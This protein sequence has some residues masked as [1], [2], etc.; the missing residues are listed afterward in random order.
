MDLEQTKVAIK[1]LYNHRYHSLNKRVSYALKQAKEDLDIDFGLLSLHEMKTVSNTIVDLECEKTHDELEDLL[2]QKEAIESKLQH[3]KQEL[4]NIKY[5]IFNTLEEQLNEDDT[6]SVSKLHQIK[7]QSIDIY[8]I[9]SETVESAII[10]AQE[11]STDIQKNDNIQVIITEITYQ[12]IKEGSLN[13]IRTRKILSTILHSVITVA[14]ADPNNGAHLLSPTL[15]GMRS[16][17]L[18]SIERFKRRVA[19]MPLE[20][21]HI[22]IEDYDTIMQDLNQVD[23]LFTQVVQVQAN[24]STPHIRQIL[25]ELNQTM[26][27]DLQELLEISKETAGVVKEKVSDFTKQ[28]VK[29]ADEALNS[30][31]AKEAKQMGIQA[32]GIAKDALGTAIKSA[33][34]AMDKK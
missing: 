5:A 32:W 23:T 30:D 14:E 10:T 3:K 11:R 9:L 31:K 29:K 18:H 22:L 17:L 13:S 34:D 20:A 12:A 6:S 27:L 19:F 21:K 24:E 4:Q 7:L 1:K 15:K 28:A 2:L 33:K 8:D 26:N 16:G 25:V